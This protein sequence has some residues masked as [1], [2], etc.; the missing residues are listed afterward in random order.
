MTRR[1]NVTGYIFIAVAAVL[2]AGLITGTVLVCR[3]P[4]TD[5][6]GEVKASDVA[7]N[8]AVI[9]SPQTESAFRM[10]VGKM[11]NNIASSVADQITVDG[12][13]LEAPEIKN[14]KY[15]SEPLLNL[16][17]KASIPTNKLLAFGEYL[18]S[19][20]SEQ[21]VVEVIDF[22]LEGDPET[23]TAEFASP[24]KLAGLLT[25]K[26][27]VIGAMED[28]IKHTS[29]TTNE[30]ARLTYECLLSIS[31]ETASQAIETLGRD[32]FVTLV[33]S[34]ST[35]YDAYLSFNMKGGTKNEA[36]L[37]GELLY[38]TGTEIERMAD[39]IGMDR[40]VAALSAGQG[41]AID[42]T[43]LQKFLETSG[44]GAD[45]IVS[46]ERLN[47]A[48]KSASNLTASVLYFA[49]SAFKA[50][51]NDTLEALASYTESV[52][53][54]TPDERYL[55][56]YGIGV[57]RAAVE[58]VKNAMSKGN[59][60]EEEILSAVAAL[61]LDT[62]AFSATPPEDKD[63]RLAEI[64]KEFTDLYANVKLVESKYGNVST[65][66]A[67]GALS[68]EERAELDNAIGAIR[69]FDY[70]ALTSGG[71]ELVSVILV[72]VAFNAISGI[73]ANVI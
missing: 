52:N 49:E 42:P 38:E 73:I 58:G 53:D 6:A 37:L 26:V 62:E 24:E 59:K 55:T 22:L 25:G 68:D 70:G 66:A 64:K 63:A 9:Y 5:Y 67:Y 57:S 30:C 18:A 11:L 23:G 7:T 51:G 43:K 28:V 72:N 17:S 31:D 20:D 69:A 21:A 50:V 33:V 16:F 45:E 29:L 13:K 15:V 40:I 61:K 36:R 47:N 8:V 54:G 27:D 48:V 39:T 41:S 19:L 65:V 35:V 46:I 14:S 1:K 60:T 10:Y 3:A 4:Q 12:S 2:I 44:Y 71:G 32:N 56:V 34:L